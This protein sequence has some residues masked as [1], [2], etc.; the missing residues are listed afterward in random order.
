[1]SIFDALH[2]CSFRATVKIVNGSLQLLL[3]KTVNSLSG[4]YLELDRGYLQCQL[5]ALWA[6]LASIGLI[7]VS[8]FKQ[9]FV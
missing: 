3:K 2:C 9:N 4:C 1:M 7:N 8:S 5:A 6:W